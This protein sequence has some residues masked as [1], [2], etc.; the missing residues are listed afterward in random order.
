[1][2]WFSNRAGYWN[3]IITEMSSLWIII[4]F[5]LPQ[6]QLADD[7]RF[8]AKVGNVEEYDIEDIVIIDAL[9]IWF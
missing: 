5:T 1:V 9:V 2:S 6:T 3:L 7:S 8:K 4:Y